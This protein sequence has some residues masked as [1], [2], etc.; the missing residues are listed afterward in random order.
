M[1]ILGLSLK[2]L[3]RHWNIGLCTKK[4]YDYSEGFNL[5]DQ[6]ERCRQAKT[7]VELL[8]ERIPINITNRRV[9]EGRK[10]SFLGVARPFLFSFHP[11]ALTFIAFFDVHKYFTINSLS[12]CRTYFHMPVV[13]ISGDVMV[14]RRGAILLKFI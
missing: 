11:H 8:T 12:L 1:F 4:T 9:S 7:T 13:L 6:R 14:V 5:Q 2:V 3:N 10:C